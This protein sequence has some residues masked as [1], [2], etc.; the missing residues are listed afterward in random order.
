MQRQLVLR[1]WRVL[2]PHLEHGHRV[3]LETACALLSTT[4][5]LA[6]DRDDDSDRVA[7]PPAPLTRT[8]RHL[9]TAA[10]RRTTTAGGE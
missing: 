6:R 3:Q 7:L 10:W 1:R 4:G 2:A 9:D 8:A 5:F